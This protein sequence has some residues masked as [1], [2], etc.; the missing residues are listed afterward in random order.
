L[1]VLEAVAVAPNGATA[2]QIAE[3]L[4]L[5]LPTTYHLLNTLIEAGHVVHLRDRHVYGLGHKA[6]FLG[7]ALSRQLSVTPEIAGAIRTVHHFADAAAYYAI[8]R[9]TDVVIAHVEDSARR[10]RV[11]PLDVGIHQAV[12]ATAFGKIMLAAMTE[13]RRTRYLDSNALPALTAST[14][15]DRTA[16]ED[17]LSHVR[18]SQLA[19]E[20]EEFQNGVACMASPV[21]DPTGNVVS[22]V[23]ISLPTAEFLSRRWSLE[24]TVRQGAVRV[25]RSLAHGARETL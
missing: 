8:Y 18:R 16:L 9:D 20:I 7:Q 3:D 21:H 17:H 13:D 25:T 15:C 14:I 11:Q 2:R 24:R 1:R 23:A 5:T 6:R 22:S 19:L 10:P 4:G 12:H